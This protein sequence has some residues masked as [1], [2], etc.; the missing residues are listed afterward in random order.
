M[1][2]EETPQAPGIIAAFAQPDES[3]APR[4]GRRVVVAEDPPQEGWWRQALSEEICWRARL[5]E[6]IL[7]PA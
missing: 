6:L 2:D 7:P 1:S 5:E 4:R 3:E